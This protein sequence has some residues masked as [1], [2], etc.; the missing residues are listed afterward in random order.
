VGQTGAT[1]FGRARADAELGL[2]I[3]AIDEP[4]RATYG[5]PRIHA[6]LAAQ[7]VR[8]GRKRTARLMEVAGRYG[9]SRR[10]WITTTM[11]DRGTRPAPIWSNATSARQRRTG[12]GWPT[13]PTFRPG[14]AF[15]SWRRY[16]TRSAAQWWAMETPLRTE[17]VLSA[18]NLALGQPRP[19]AVIHH[20]DQGSQYT[21]IAFGMR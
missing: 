15:C 17:L 14:P 9:V 7:G 8:V 21:S 2:R 5:A 20:S 6:E 11:R 4:S 16:S 12:G 18:L 13:S 3:R 1:R 19:A 10:K